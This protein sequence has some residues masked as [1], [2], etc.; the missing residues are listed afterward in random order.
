MIESSAARG[1]SSATG[2]ERPYPPLASSNTMD[3]WIEIVR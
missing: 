1:M 2:C 3:P